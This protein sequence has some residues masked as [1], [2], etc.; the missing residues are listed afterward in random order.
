MQAYLKVALALWCP[1]VDVATVVIIIIKCYEKAGKF[2]LKTTKKGVLV[3]NNL[4]VT[5]EL[6]V[7]NDD[8]L[9]K[10]LFDY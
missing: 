7:V 9:H 8:E 2:S 5:Y 10:H 1:T 4:V 6:I 3:I